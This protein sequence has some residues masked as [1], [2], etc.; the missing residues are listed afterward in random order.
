VQLAR[1]A[2]EGDYSGMKYLPVLMII[3]LPLGAQNAPT[4]AAVIQ[5]IRERS[6][7]S[8]KAPT[9]DTFK[10]GDST[11]RVTG[12]AVTMMATLDVLK[13]AAEKGDNLVITH[14]PTFY[15]HRDTTGALES[16]G[17]QVLA[18]KRKF[19]DEH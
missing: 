11:A 8:V 7:A 9:V 16:E 1:N 12:I 13:R 2:L 18:A 3:A 6:A 10:T 15:S 4:A 5:A 17:D 14:E 19:I